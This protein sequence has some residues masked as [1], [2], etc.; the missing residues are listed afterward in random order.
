MLKFPHGL[1]PASFLR[2]Y[3]QLKP[4]P[5]PGALPEF[6]NP[7]DAE[8]LAFVPDLDLRVL[9]RFDPCE[10]HVLEPGDILY[11]P[12]R[13]PH[14]GIAEGPCITCSIGFRAPTWRELTAP[15]CEFAAEKGLSEGRFADRPLAPRADSG[16]ILPEVVEQ[17]RDVLTAGVLDESG[18]LLSECLG[19][20]VTEPKEN[21]DP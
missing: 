7:L 8:D 16:E 13:V 1:D 3:W 2:S 14:W 18:R 4:L 20:F 10:E 15:W 19:P 6:Q 11:L 17:V 9:Q 12:P 21:L 5:M